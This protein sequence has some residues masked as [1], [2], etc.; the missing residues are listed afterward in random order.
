MSRYFGSSSRRVDRILTSHGYSFGVAL[1]CLSVRCCQNFLGSA[2]KLLADPKSILAVIVACLASFRTLYTRS[3]RAKRATPIDNDSG[4][5]ALFLG[6]GHGVPQNIRGLN[7]TSVTTRED[8]RHKR[9]GS[10]ASSGDF[11]LPMN[12][13]YVQREY[14]VV[15]ESKISHEASTSTQMYDLP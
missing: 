14:N 15:P 9:Q 8:S 2:S 3:D 4:K 1:N 5:A 7:S 13:V 11:I 6:N 12:T 10:A